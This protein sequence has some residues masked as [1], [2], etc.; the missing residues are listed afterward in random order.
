MNEIRIQKGALWSY[1]SLLEGLEED[2]IFEEEHYK[3]YVEKFGENAPRDG[4]T[5]ILFEDFDIEGILYTFSEGI[6]HHRYLNV[7]E[8]KSLTYK[9]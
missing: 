6:T 9:V 2:I 1:F 5:I 4:I 8:M 7:K 3:L